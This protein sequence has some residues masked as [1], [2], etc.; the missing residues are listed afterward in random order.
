MKHARVPATV[1]VP[2]CLLL[3]LGSG[4]AGA[5]LAAWL[6]PNSGLAGA[7][8]LLALPAAFL[9]GM[10]L[11]IGIALLRALPYGLLRLLGRRPATRPIDD[12][13]CVPPGAFGFVPCS[14]LFGG[15][16]G[17]VVAIV[18]VSLGALATMALYLA[19]GAGHGILCWQAARRGWLPFPDEA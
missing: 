18:S 1:T 11:W 10:Y 5:G 3:F 17:V 16:A 4:G 9:L 7:V 2:V 6:A 13:A 15:L 14:M 19:A 8:S 12:A